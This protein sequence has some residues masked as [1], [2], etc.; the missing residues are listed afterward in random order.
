MTA[1]GLLLLALPLLT[2]EATPAP[3]KTQVFLSAD[4]LVAGSE[5]PIAVKATIADGWHVNAQPPS[6]D[7]LIP[8]TLT[9]TGDQGTVLT[10]TLYPAG[11]ATDQ[12]GL[13]VSTYEGEV[14]MFGTLKVPTDRIGQTETLSI[15]TSYQACNAK[16][17]RPQ[18]TTT[19]KGRIAIVAP[20][21]QVRAMNASVFQK[22]PQV[23]SEGTVIPAH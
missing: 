18:A 3:V 23:A 4:K 5:V 14:W 8:I 11:H 12:G 19:I 21:T 17:C 20:G 7:Y 2:A 6:A 9:V 16:T 13:S 15:A 10:Q 22:Q 1:T